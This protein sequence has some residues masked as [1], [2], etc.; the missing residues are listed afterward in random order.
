MGVGAGLYMY[1]VVVKSLRVLSHLLMSNE[2]LL[3]MV[4]LCNRETIY[5][6]IL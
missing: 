5:I 3:F 4:A 6:F 1:D 2:F